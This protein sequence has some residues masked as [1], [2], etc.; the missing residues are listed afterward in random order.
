MIFP[1]YETNF[2]PF[3]AKDMCPLKTW[4]KVNLLMHS[5]LRALKSA[6]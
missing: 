4:D 5:A 3:V 6:I 2:Y 1:T